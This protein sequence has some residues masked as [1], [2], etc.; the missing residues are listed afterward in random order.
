VNGID[1][2]VAPVENAILEDS[3]AVLCTV[4]TLL[5]KIVTEAEF[6]V[7]DVRDGPDITG[8]DL[9]VEAPVENTSLEGDEVVL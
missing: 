7:P 1:V 4:P 2:V 5:G 8:V 6:R 9:G 3:K